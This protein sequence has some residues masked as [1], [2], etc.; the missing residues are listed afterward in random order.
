MFGDPGQWVQFVI[1]LVSI[2]AAG[3][4]VYAAIRSDIAVLHA[5]LINARE[6]IKELQKDV[7]RHDREIASLD[8]RDHNQ[9]G[10]HPVHGG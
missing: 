4:G 7:K 9:T 3:M 10:A 8:R 2:V 5:N 1:Q 6:D